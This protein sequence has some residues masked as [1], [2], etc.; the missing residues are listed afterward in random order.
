M[1]LTYLC[2]AV[3]V[4]NRENSSQ[5]IQEDLCQ[6]W[7]ELGGGHQHIYTVTPVGCRQTLHVSGG[8]TA[9]TTSDTERK[10]TIKGHLELMMDRDLSACVSQES[11]RASTSALSCSQAS[12]LAGPSRPEDGSE[13]EC[14]LISQSDAHKTVHSLHVFTCL[15]GW[16]T[17]HIVFVR[18]IQFFDSSV[19]EGQFPHPVNPAADT[20]SQAQVGAG[21]SCMEAISCKTVSTV[22]NNDMF[23]LKNLLCW[24][25]KRSKN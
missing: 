12:L 20:R 23:Y 18:G 8:W 22:D 5:T 16:L 14:V 13:S 17:P 4:L 25:K 10:Y 15:S 21:C 2:C 19:A 11:V 6:C 7:Y 24:N 3:N 9:G 1:R